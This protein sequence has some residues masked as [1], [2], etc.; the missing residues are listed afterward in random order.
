[1]YDLNHFIRV[2]CFTQHTQSSAGCLPFY[3]FRSISVSV[4]IQ[5]DSAGAEGFPS[6]F[7]SFRPSS[8]DRRTHKDTEGVR[9]IGHGHTIPLE[10]VASML[11]MAEMAWKALEHRRDHMVIADEA[12]LRAENRQLRTL[13]ADNL[14]LLQTI[15]DMPVVSKDCPADLHSRLL[16]AVESSSFLGKLELLHEGSK[17]G[18]PTPKSTNIN[19]EEVPIQVDDGEVCW[20]IWITHETTPECLEEISGI[21]NENYV[22]ISEENVV[23]GISDFVARCILEHPKSKVLTPDELQKDKIVNNNNNTTLSM[24]SDIGLVTH[25]QL[26]IRTAPCRHRPPDPCPISGAHYSS[27]S[28]VSH[29]SSINPPAF[30]TRSPSLSLIRQ[31]HGKERRN[32]EEEE[33]AMGC[34]FAPLSLPISCFLLLSFLLIHFNQLFASLN[35]LFLASAGLVVVSVFVFLF[36]LLKLIRARRVL[37]VRW[38]IGDGVSGGVSSR[39]TTAGSSPREGVVFHSN[40]DVYEGELHKGRCGGSGVYIFYGKGKY[41]GDWVDGKYEGHGVESWAKGSQYRGQYRQGMRHGFGVYRF[42]SGD[43]Y[44]G[45]WASGQ[46]HGIGLQSCSDGSS[47]AGEFKCGVKHGLGRYCFRNGDRYSG[48]YFRDKIH[49]FGVYNFTNGHC[50]EGSWHEGRRQGFGTYKFRNGETRSGEW[51]CGIL[52]NSLLPSD[53]AIERN[54]EAARKASENATLLPSMEDQVKKAVSAAKKAATAARVAS[55]RAI[56]NQ[57]KG[58]FS[59]IHV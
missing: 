6:L 21:D 54:T 57:K 49:G 23:D 33:E 16:A 55:I 58:R 39:W 8:A 28:G 11:E 5:F 4:F 34:A 45:E 2:C 12:Q 25:L 13:L 26:R 47:Y 17:G 43:S 32:Q 59:D 22:I 51:D 46:S 19:G 14:A 7:L 48:E 53:P 44:A 36:R 9:M 37:P 15:C 27:S 30:S 29:T 50:Y 42:Y 20:W 1:M 10:V 24:G 56:Q 35:A 40:G 3:R 52:K 41:E 18:V 31:N 38:S